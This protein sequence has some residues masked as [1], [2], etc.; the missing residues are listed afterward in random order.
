M[1]LQKYCAFLQ[2]NNIVDYTV[3]DDTD[4]ITF[5]CKRI[6]KTGIN[7]E[8]I[9][10]NTEKI[11]I[12]LEMTH[13]SFVDFCILSG[14]DYSDTIQQIGPVTAL[15][16]IK[17][18]KNIEEVIKNICKNTENFNYL[19]ARNIFINFNY[20]IPEHVA[21]RDADFDNLMIFLTENKIKQNVI[22]KFV[23]II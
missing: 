16:L 8:I 22:S 20:E 6:L 19:E 10:I 21:K 23:K 15:N 1:S 11:L 9:E 2:N 3:T 17:K 4:A 7:K 13:S 18:H 5:G 12:D 14:C